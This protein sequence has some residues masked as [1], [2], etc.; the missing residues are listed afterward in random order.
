MWALGPLV[1]CSVVKLA[2]SA[3]LT[4]EATELLTIHNF[5]GWDI[6]SWRA[7]NA[8]NLCAWE[9]VECDSENAHVQELRLT[10][11]VTYD[12]TCNLSGLDASTAFDAAN[13]AHVERWELSGIGLTGEA[14]ESFFQFPSNLIL[15][16]AENQ[17]SG[18]IETFDVTSPALQTIHL[19]SNQFSGSMC[20]L[21]R[22]TRIT[23]IDI[24]NN[25]FSGDIVDR[26]GTQTRLVSLKL[27]NNNF[28]GPIPDFTAGQEHLTVIR[29]D[30]NKFSG[31]IPEHL[32]SVGMQGSGIQARCPLSLWCSLHTFFCN[33]CLGVAAGNQSQ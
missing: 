25:E 2:R 30:S 14:P 28:T 23:D 32:A 18:Q 9:F 8:A 3:A 16:L 5:C 4:Q 12:L 33:I 19:Y 11:S 20:S 6:P 26:L 22:H 24:S 10:A 15:N 13:L 7:D 29:L 17:L 31:S 27:T 21:E 1:V